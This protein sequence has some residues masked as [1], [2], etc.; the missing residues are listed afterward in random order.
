VVLIEES[1]ID[2]SS[3]K[4]KVLRAEARRKTIHCLGATIPVLYLF[5][6]KEW[7]MLGFFVGFA[8]IALLEWLRLHG[9][10]SLPCLRDY[11]GTRIGAYVFFV[12]SAFLSILL[13]EKRIAIAA[14]LMLAFGDTVSALAGAVLNTGQAAPPGKRIKPPSVMLAMFLTSLLIGLLVLGPGA[15]A[16]LGAIGA[17][18][19]DGVPLQVRQVPVNDNLTI[20][21]VAGCLMS[22]GSLC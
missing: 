18:I 9:R 8:N 7:L 1:F 22:I 5:F 17:T 21:L 4:L 10:L 14:I 12:I 20:P 6:P 15:A 2:M 19:A 3:S 11:E 13:F 16:V